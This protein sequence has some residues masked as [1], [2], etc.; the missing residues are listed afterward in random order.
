MSFACLGWGSLIWNPETLPLASAWSKDGPLLPLEFARE[1]QDGR[2]TL[3]I[4]DDSAPVRT[5]WAKLDV[6]SID[7]AVQALFERER[8]EW[9]GSI[10]RWPLSGRAHRY[11][12]EIGSW[13]ETKGLQGVVW[14]DLKAGFRPDRKSIPTLEQTEQ[15]MLALSPDARAKAAEYVLNA[16]KQ[17]AT[18]FRPALERLLR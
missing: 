16:P 10:G 2:M 3:V 15:H 13:A 9:I 1:S 6:R 18:P 7:D 14:T 5:L 11:S 4:V 8:A 17:I 12:A